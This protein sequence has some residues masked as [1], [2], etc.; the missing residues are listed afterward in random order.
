[1][2][3]KRSLSDDVVVMAEDSAVAFEFVAIAASTCVADVG[4]VVG[5][6]IFWLYLVVISSYGYGPGGCDGFRR[7]SCLL[8]RRWLCCGLGIVGVFGGSSSGGF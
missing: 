6:C 3:L 4:E 8:W 7:W 5:W 1:M 2:A